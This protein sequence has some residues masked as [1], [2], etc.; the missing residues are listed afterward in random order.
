MTSGLRNILILPAAVMML[1][2]VLSGTAKNVSFTPE[3]DELKAD[4]LFMEALRHHEKDADDAYYDLLRRAYELDPS[5][6]DVAFYLG[7]YSVMIA[8]EDSVTFQRGYDMMKSH[9]D[10]KPEDFYCNFVYGSINDQLGRRDEALRVWSVM[11]SV[12]P[13]K[14]DVAYKLAEAL[15]ASQ[16][17]SN[18]AK[19][20]DVYRRIEKA[21]GKNIPISTRKIRAYFVSQ[22]TVSI[23]NEVKELLASSPR[24]SENN[25]FAGD[26]YA[27][28]SERDSALKYYNRACE[29]DP[30]SGLAYYSR[31]NFYKSIDDSVSYDREV[32]QAL[33]QESLELDTKLE[34]LT[35]YIR[36][37]YEDPTQQPRIQELFATLLEQHPHEVAIHDLYCSYLIAIEDYEQ[38]AEQMGYA[39]DIDPASEERWRTLMSLDIQNNDFQKAVK[40]GERAVHYHPQSPLINLVLGSAYTQL[41]EYDKGLAALNRSLE[42]TDSAD[43]E[44]VSQVLS[45]IGDA[46]YAKGDADSAFVYYDK[47][48]ATNPSNLLALNN[49]A[50]YLAEAGKDLDKAERMSAVTI[51]E[52]PE[53]ATSLDT[54]AWIMFKK[55]NYV[56]AMV[57]IDKAI[58]NSSE[59]SEELFHHAGDIYFMNKEYDEAIDFWKKALALDPDNE[60][61]KKKVKHKAYFYE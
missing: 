34:L 20:I 33:K 42:Y 61:L 16:D 51:K 9:F 10:S 56:E 39:V 46:Y 11:D 35:S 7:Y 44:S 1:F 18:V 55:N 4:Y 52:D 40:E 8:R 36:A 21:Q 5:N 57:Y 23:F 2:S 47:A 19:S 32:F 15:V 6:T 58:E 31:A 12:F 41:K 48:I 53:N 25:V 59:P 24:S 37:L 29:I 14:P 49:C 13:T 30:T 45:S 54:Y 60:L 38:A 26:I 3:A 43:Y 17:S 28:F 27:M 50:Y 22:D